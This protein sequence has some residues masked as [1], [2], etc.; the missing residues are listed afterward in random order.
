[1]N[2]T[3]APW[4][5]NPS[6]AEGRKRHNRQEQDPAP[7]KQPMGSGALTANELHKAENNSSQRRSH[8]YLHQPWCGQ[9]RRQTHPL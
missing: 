2:P 8:M 9:Q 5:G 3:E 4:S 1:M 7:A 6:D